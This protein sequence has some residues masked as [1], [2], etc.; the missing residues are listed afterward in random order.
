MGEQLHNSN[1]V[2]TKDNQLEERNAD[3]Y[4]K[5]VVTNRGSLTKRDAKEESN[6]EIE[7]L[8]IYHM[9]KVVFCACLWIS[10]HFT[11]AETEHIKALK[12]SCIKHKEVPEVEL[13][14]KT[15]TTSQF[16]TLR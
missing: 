16:R 3:I 14:R 10:C 15:D 13:G 11:Y 1:L 4:A 9:E 6:W 7:G 5:E 8:L 2:K 12:Y